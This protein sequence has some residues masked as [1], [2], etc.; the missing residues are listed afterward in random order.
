MK[1]L[2]FLFAFILTSTI[3]FSQD[4]SKLEN[5]EFSTD[6]DYKKAEDRVLNGVNYLFNTPF[7]KNDTSRTEIL[8]FIIQWMTDTPD[9]TFTIDSSAVELTKG[10]SDLFG[11]YVAGMAKVVLESK[12][13]LPTN[14]TIHNI[15][16]QYLI[17][18]TSDKSNNM[19]PTKAL[20]KLTKG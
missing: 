6:E 14:E 17:D 11:M 4:S 10:N 5:Y 19:K 13:A 1:N 16:T 2:L 3:T 9:Y 20:K 18:Y 15:V 12:S 7:D 8:A